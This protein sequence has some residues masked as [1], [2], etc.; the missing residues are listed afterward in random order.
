LAVGVSAAGDR[1]FQALSPALDLL[2]GGADGSPA[3]LSAGEK[4]LPLLVEARPAL[5]QARSDLVAVEQAR[6]RIDAA[7]LS[8]RV[9]GLVA[10]LDDILPLFGAAVDGALLLPDLLGADGPR[11]YLVIAQNNQELRA[12]G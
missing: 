3:L 10:R 4:M 11:T 5:E 8:P 12:T 7:A 6:E 1:T 9:A 2:E